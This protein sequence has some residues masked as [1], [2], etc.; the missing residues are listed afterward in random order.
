[1][2]GIHY[3]I[4]MY[5]CS[6]QIETLKFIEVRGMKEGDEHISYWENTVL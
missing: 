3:F 1:M 6:F 4:R 2:K 5:V